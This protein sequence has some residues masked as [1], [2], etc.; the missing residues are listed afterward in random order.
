[1]TRRKGL[2]RGLDAL[3]GDAAGRGAGAL[4]AGGLREIPVDLVERNPYQPR[5]RIEER[6]L[7]E[8]AASIAARGM[9]QPVLVRPCADGRRFEL[10]AGERRW[11]AAQRAGLAVIPALVREASDE[12]AAAIALIENVQRE[13]LNPIEEAEALRRLVEEFGLTH[14][15]VAEAVGRSRAAVSN[16]LRLLELGPEARAALE[17]GEIEMGHARALLGLEGAAQ[18]EAVRRVVSGGLSVRETERL[19]RRLRA[20]GER[21]TRPA[22]ASGDPDIRRLETDLGER[23]GAAVSIRHGPRGAGRVV[24][25]YSSL[26]QLEGILERVR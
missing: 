26:E 20:G 17:G 8:L 19:V 9:V 6:G 7:E 3:L 4:A 5:T 13:D 11:R 15:R 25:R 21:R 10:I 16:L 14:Q 24:I 1:M 22:A 23:L 18:R 12:E 2:G